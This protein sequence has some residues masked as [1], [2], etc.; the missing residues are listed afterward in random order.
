MRPCTRRFEPPE[1][2]TDERGR[3]EITF[4]VPIEQ[5]ALRILA[6]GYAPLERPLGSPRQ[7]GQEYL[8]NITI[9][10]GSVLSGTVVDDGGRPVAGVEVGMGL[11]SG[12]SSGPRILERT[13]TGP[14]G[15]FPGAGACA[16]IG[17]EEPH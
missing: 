8:G 1:A 3:F 5:A 11:W 6:R 16:S 7:P 10:R 13:R 4:P 14:D 2:D 15:L 9:L 17:G 12:D